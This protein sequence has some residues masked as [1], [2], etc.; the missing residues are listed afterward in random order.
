MAL[1]LGPSGS[2][3]N[4]AMWHPNVLTK[5]HLNF[6]SARSSEDPI[7]LGKIQGAY[8]FTWVNTRNPPFYLEKHRRPTRSP[9]FYLEKHKEPTRSPPFYLEKHNHFAWKKHK[10]S[11][12]SPTGNNNIEK[13]QRRS[14]RGEKRRLQFCNNHYYTTAF[15]L[16][17]CLCLT[18]FRKL[19]LKGA[20]LNKTCLYMLFSKPPIQLWRSNKQNQT[21]R[22]KQSK[23]NNLPTKLPTKQTTKRSTNHQTATKQNNPT[24]KHPTNQQNKFNK[25]HQ[26]KTNQTKPSKT[27]K[28]QTKQIN[29]PTNQPTNTDKQKTTEPYNEDDSY[30]VLFAMHKKI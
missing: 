13:W 8:Q 25:P 11:N 16:R 19:N 24:S 18:F 10:E 9:P 12:L 5:N 30:S 1:D 6:I 17:G 2:S 23:P 7:L 4:I 21:N 26:T 20:S 29:H 14:G 28:K 22:T 27:R 15:G 3:K